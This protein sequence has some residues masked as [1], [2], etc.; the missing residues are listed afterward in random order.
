MVSV[1]LANC[2]TDKGRSW[3]RWGVIGFYLPLGGAARSASERSLRVHTPLSPPSR[4]ALLR[5]RSSSPQG[6]GVSGGLRAPLP[7]G[8]GEN[9]QLCSPRNEPS[10]FPT[11]FLRR[12]ISWP[13]P[14]RDVGP[15]TARLWPAMLCSTAPHVSDTESR[16]TGPAGRRRDIIPGLVLRLHFEGTR[17]P[18]ASDRRDVALTGFFLRGWRPGAARAGRGRCDYRAVM[19]SAKPCARTLRQACAVRQAGMVLAAAACVDDRASTN[20]QFAG[21][22]LRRRFSDAAVAVTVMGI[23]RRWSRRGERVDGA[24]RRPQRPASSAGKRAAR[25]AQSGRGRA[26]DRSRCGDRPQAQALHGRRRGLRMGVD[27]RRDRRRRIVGGTS[28]RSA[29]RRDRRL[30]RRFAA[31]ADRNRRPAAREGRQAW[32]VSL[33]AHDVLDGVASWPRVCI[34]APAIR[35]R[36]HARLPRTASAPRRT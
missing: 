35:S 13:L 5:A 29:H 28:P 23:G 16:S 14:R 10:R 20:K 18:G 19:P 27:A 15:G 36:R 7:C 34:P 30:R 21:A 24:A 2:C 12:A 3:I 17:V 22:F 11:S 32:S 6:R 9:G 26:A 25:T 33:A 4:P 1:F 8:L 31:M